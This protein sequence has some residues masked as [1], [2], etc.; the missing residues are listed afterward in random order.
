[1]NDLNKKIDEKK[2]QIEQ[3][4]Q[5]ISDLEDQLRKDGLPAGWSR[6]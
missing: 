1:L 2:Q 5:A 6:P 3:D 4:K